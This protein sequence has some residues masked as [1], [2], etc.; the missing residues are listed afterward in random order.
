MKTSSLPTGVLAAAALLL[1]ACSSAPREVAQTQ[2]AEPPARLEAKPNLRK[3]MTETEIRSAWG[4]PMAVHTSPEGDTILVYHFDV[5]TT[6]RMVAAA[7]TEVPSADLFT[8][9]AR[10]VLEPTLT[11][12]K[13]T[14]TQTIVLQLK[15]GV[16]AGWARKLGEERSFN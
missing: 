2:P 8:G 12:E 15:A 16:L 3:G 10:T 9:E 1:A 11:P 13:V 14:L 5:L 4:E 7:M 6:Q